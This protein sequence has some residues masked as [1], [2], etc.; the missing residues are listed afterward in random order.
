MTDTQERIVGRQIY[1]LGVMDDDGNTWK[2][3]LK[4]TDM[5][6]ILSFLD[7]HQL[8]WMYAKG[9]TESEALQWQSEAGTSEARKD[10]V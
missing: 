2:Q 4:T 1:L 8:E 3:L 5:S 7:D 10:V 9:M 6:G